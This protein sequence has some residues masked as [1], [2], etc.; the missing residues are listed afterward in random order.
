MTNVIKN[1]N[2]KLQALTDNGMNQTSKASFFTNKKSNI[3]LKTSPW[4]HHQSKIE[5]AVHKERKLAG[6]GRLNPEFVGKTPWVN[7]SDI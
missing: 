4:R 1:G 7:D 3:S 2:V 5:L 6:N